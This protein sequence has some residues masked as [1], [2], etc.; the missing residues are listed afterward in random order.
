MS[1]E[2]INEFRVHKSVQNSCS[3]MSREIIAK[4][5]SLWRACYLAA[6]TPCLTGPVDY[7]FAS[8][9]E[10]PGFNPQGGTYMKPGFSC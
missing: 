7:L 6:F 4:S 5:K 9:H 3:M 2:K 8:P 10:G 1:S